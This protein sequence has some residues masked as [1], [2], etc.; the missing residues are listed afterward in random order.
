MTRSFNKEK[1]KYAK[2]NTCLLSFPLSTKRQNC[3]KKCD[4]EAIIK[5]VMSY[6]TS[7]DY[8]ICIFYFNF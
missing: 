1:R 8:F 7:Y 3:C 4:L 5:S 2:M 6:F